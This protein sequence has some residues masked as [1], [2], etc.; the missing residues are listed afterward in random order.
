MLD[1]DLDIVYPI[2]TP[3]EGSPFGGQGISVMTRS[4]L[5]PKLAAGLIRTN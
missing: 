1:F 2:L 5:A 4:D 3:D